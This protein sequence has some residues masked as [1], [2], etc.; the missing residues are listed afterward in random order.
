MAVIEGGQAPDFTLMNQEREPVTLSNLRG[1][2][3]V[4][5]FFPAA[6]ASHGAIDAAT[7]AFAILAREGGEELVGPSRQLSPGTFWDGFRLE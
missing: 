5:A 3:V 2:P 6:F 1:R 4:L 7:A